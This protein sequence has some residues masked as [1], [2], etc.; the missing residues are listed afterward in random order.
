MKSSDVADVSVL[1]VTEVVLLSAKHV[2][3]IEFVRD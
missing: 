1:D 3:I 2:I